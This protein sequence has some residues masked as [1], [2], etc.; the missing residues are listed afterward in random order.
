M[1]RLSCSTYVVT[2]LVQELVLSNSR[3]IGLLAATI[4]NRNIGVDGV[5]TRPILIWK[6]VTLRGYVI[7]GSDTDDVNG[8]DVNSRRILNLGGRFQTIFL[9]NERDT[10]VLS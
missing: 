7:G 9:T 10:S 2:S 4:L 8:H 3:L 1:G 5:V 6:L